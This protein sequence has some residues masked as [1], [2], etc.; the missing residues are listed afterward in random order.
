MSYSPLLLLLFLPA[1]SAA[2][3]RSQWNQGTITIPTSTVIS[4]GLGFLAFSLL[5]LLFLLSFRVNRIRKLAKRQN[6]SFKRCWKDEGGLWSFFTSFGEGDGHAASSTLIGATGRG[7][8]YNRQLYRIYRELEGDSDNNKA[9]EIPKIWDCNWNE[10]VDK[11]QDWGDDKIQPLSVTPSAPPTSNTSK[12]YPPLPTL[13]MCVL[14]TFPSESTNQA[15][16]DLPQMIIG[17]TTLLPT[18]TIPDKVDPQP[19]FALSS[20]IVRNSEKE[21][22]QVGQITK[23][24]VIEHIE[25]SRVRAE[26]KQDDS[27]G[28][29]YIDGLRSE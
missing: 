8:D 10:N 11:N 7:L 14:I 18:I 4:I 26:W 25:Y 28:V 23:K 27:K 29:W 16:L 9:K 15:D 1:T 17:T 5:I 20:S 12:T 22:L 3:D 2:N 21:G 19:D 24:V 6:K 13:D